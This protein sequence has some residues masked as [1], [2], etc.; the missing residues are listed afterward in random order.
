M[1][2]KE[3]FSTPEINE[4][5]ETKQFQSD[6]YYKHN[7]NKEVNEKYDTFEDSSENNK[8]LDYFDISHGNKRNKTSKAKK[9]MSKI[10]SLPSTIG[11]GAIAL[12]AG[13]IIAITIASGVT[14][15]MPNVNI[16]INDIGLDYISYD[17][18]IDKLNPGLDYIVKV[19]NPNQEIDSSCNEGVNSY[20]VTG[21]NPNETYTIALIGKNKTYGN[22][23]TY[24]ESNFYTL[25][26]GIESVEIDVKE[27]FDN[28]NLSVGFDYYV[29]VL[30]KAKDNNY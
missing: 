13:A 12:I 23:Y 30:N 3:Y 10:L 18:E 19:S 16:S 1:K 21:L 6:E 5:K 26:D 2:D 11:T 28:E 25:T 14:D 8:R 9:V 22:T 7:G 24:Y 17:M 27:T 20:L 4:I 15:V 29:S